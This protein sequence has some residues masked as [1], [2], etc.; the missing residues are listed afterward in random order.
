[1]TPIEFRR[2]LHR[3]PELSFQEYATAHFIAEQL[4]LCGIDNR[5]IAKTGVVAKI[6]GRGDLRRAVVLRADID[7]LPIVEATGLDYA[8]ENDGIMH[9]CGHDIHA[10][11]LFGV[12]QRLALERDFEGTIFGLFQ[13]GEEC[14]PGGASLVLAEEPFAGYDVVAVVGEHTDPSLEVGTF[15]FREGQYMASSDELRFTLR[16]KG[17]HAAMRDRLHD[18]ILAQAELVSTILSMNGAGRIISL[19]RIEADG[20]TNV[21]PDMVYIEGTMRTFSEQVRRDTKEQIAAVADGIA[22]RHSITVDV[23]INHGYPSVVNDVALTRRAKALAASRFRVVELDLRPTA[24]DFGYYCLHYPSL[25]YRIGVGTDAGAQHT[26]T[27]SPDEGAI[28]IGVEFMTVL[29]LKLMKD[30]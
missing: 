26:P 30:E 6:E 12:L 17:G 7:A 4:T 24:E 27:F 19:G 10:A 21:I 15:G 29:S 16:G 20:A 22:R 5:L 25:F 2:H 18:P 28:T 9:A 3:Y 8:S 11:I 13:P 23:D 14:N 1:M